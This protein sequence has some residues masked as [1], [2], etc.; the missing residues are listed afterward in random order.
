MVVDNLQKVGYN[1]LKI[2]EGGD[3]MDSL[4]LKQCRV[5]REKTQEDMAKLLNVHV[6]TYRKIEDNPGSATV[7]QAKAICEY[8]D[9][10]YDII[11]FAE[12]R[13]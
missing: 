10:D 13:V 7:D 12:R 6:Q 9:F 4:T 3:E 1:V 2:K 5:V 11:F 8:L